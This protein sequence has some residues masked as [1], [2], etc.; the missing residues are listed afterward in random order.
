MCGLQLDFGKSGMLG[1]S[2]PVD[3]KRY[4]K[5]VVLHVVVFLPA[6]LL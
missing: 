5:Q 2:E 1:M 6:C 4:K 3:A